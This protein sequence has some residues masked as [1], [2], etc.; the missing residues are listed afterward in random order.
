M[1][2]ALNAFMTIV[3]ILV[4]LLVVVAGTAIGTLVGLGFFVR[5][6]LTKDDDAS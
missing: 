5:A 1:T 6:L 4:I 3:I 2:I